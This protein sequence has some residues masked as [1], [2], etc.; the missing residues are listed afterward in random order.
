[1]KN[2]LKIQSTIF[3]F[4]KNWKFIKHEKSLIL[5]VNSN[6]LSYIFYFWRI[7]NLSIPPRKKNSNANI[8]F[9]NF[10]LIS[11]YKSLSNFVRTTNLFARALASINENKISTNN[12]QSIAS[13]HK[14]N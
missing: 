12:S 7:S 5:L 4:E 9:L 10:N 13:V 3:L 6:F 2:K 11:N 1:M 8:L 14:Q